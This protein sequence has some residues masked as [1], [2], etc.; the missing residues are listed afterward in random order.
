MTSS[1][2]PPILTSEGRA[3]LEERARRLEEETIPAVQAA[4]DES[5]DELGLQVE[6]DLA[7]RE[8]ERLH[9]VLET[10]RSVGDIP[11]DP[12][13]VQIGDWVKVKTD[14]GEISRYLIVDPAEAV[15]DVDR[16]SADSPLAHAL[17]GLKVGES[18]VIEAPSGSYTAEVVET[19][20]QA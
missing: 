11:E 16:I 15:V 5:A 14:D 10:A 13:I 19:L 1:N 4:I 3:R 9:Y 6:Y 8:L 20:R 18:A 12:D 2:E 7:T 17:L